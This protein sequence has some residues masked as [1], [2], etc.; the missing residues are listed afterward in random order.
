[1]LAIIFLSQQASFFSMMTSPAPHSAYAVKISA[2]LVLSIVLLAALSTK[3]FWLQP[4]A[5]RDLIDDENT[6]ANRAEAMRWGFLFS[7][8]AA[9]AVYAL[10]MFETDVTARDAIH[11]VMTIGIAAALVRWGILERRAHR[12][13]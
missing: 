9:I 7:M 2:W 12:D 11:I 6:R 10:T 13:G 8:G 5:V 3:G 4:K 1:M